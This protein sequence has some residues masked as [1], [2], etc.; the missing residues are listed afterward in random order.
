MPQ[1]AG[2]SSGVVGGG[3]GRGVRFTASKGQDQMIEAVKY[4]PLECERVT[5]DDYNSGWKKALSPR[6]QFTG[7]F[8]TSLELSNVSLKPRTSQ[9]S[10]LSP[11]FYVVGFCGPGTRGSRVGQS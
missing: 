1:R 7:K 11:K 5:V 4:D 8:G 10:N 6:T 2:H 3:F 9:M